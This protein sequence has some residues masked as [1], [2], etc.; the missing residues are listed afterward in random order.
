MEF[1]LQQTLNGLTLGSV[2][3]LPAIG[4]SMV[5]GI[6]KLVNFA[7]GEVYMVGAFA[8]YG[9]LRLLGGPA[10]PVAGT[11]SGGEQQMVAMGR[12]LMAKPKL[13]LMDEPSMG[14]APILVEQSFEI[15]QRVHR[16]GFPFWSS[17]RTPTWRCRSPTTA[18][19]WPLDGS[20]CRAM[21]PLWPNTR[22]SRKPTLGADRA[23]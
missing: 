5:Y 10:S 19:Y 13:L 17:S 16:A 14:L 9:V 22:N 20:C 3:A 15:I 21:P 6:L 8:G 7:H 2:Y 1:F 11:L 12:A 18:T 23:T 4:Y